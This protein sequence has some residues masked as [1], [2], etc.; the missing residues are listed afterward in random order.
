MLRLLKDSVKKASG[1]AYVEFHLLFEGRTVRNFG[2]FPATCCRRSRFTTSRED[3]GT[4]L[5]SRKTFHGSSP[6]E[7]L[8]HFAK[9]ASHLRG[10]ALPV[11]RNAGVRPHWRLLP[12]N[13]ALTDGVVEHLL[14]Y[15]VP[16][17]LL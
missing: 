9:G 14:A 3:S 4:K 6:L 12:A 15:A 7:A 10:L 11:H 2:A 5:P 13:T 8:S 16:G 17:G 1:E